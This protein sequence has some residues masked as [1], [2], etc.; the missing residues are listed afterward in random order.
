MEWKEGKRGA[1]G[2]TFDWE[3]DYPHSIYA[4]ER[5][6]DLKGD[7]PEKTGRILKILER[8]NT[9][10]TFFVVGIMAEEFRESFNSIKLA[11]HE[12]A[13][14]GDHHGGY[15]QIGV[16][17]Q[18]KVPDFG[19]QSLDEQKIR[20]KN[21]EGLLGG[22]PAG[23]RAPGLNFNEDTLLALESLGYVYDSSLQTSVET[24]PFHPRAGGKS[25]RLL[26]IPVTSGE[27][28]YSWD[29]YGRM[30]DGPDISEQWKSDFEVVYQSGG[31]Y[32]SLFHPAFIGKDSRLLGTLDG[33]LDYAL[34]HDIWAPTL[35]ELAKW[36]LGREMLN[37]EVKN[38]KGTISILVVENSGG[39]MEGL[40]IKVDG[41]VRALGKNISTSYVGGQKNNFTKI[42]FRGLDEG[43]T[44]VILVR[45]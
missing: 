6:A 18:E 10:A 38:P 29:L 9:T 21:A 44:R 32:V 25:L 34:S 11:G 26:E 42:I 4:P 28:A 45:V 37:I 13:S 20:I 17:E 40:A 36:H 14:H 2:V 41:K 31:A 1:V 12:I 5:M 24:R 7:L 22:S 30:Y 3:D 15:S 16:G 35:I 43:K 23:F 19:S 39:R 8:Y 27:N 33:F